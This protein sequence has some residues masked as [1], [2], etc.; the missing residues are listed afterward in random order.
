M[1]KDGPIYMF[2]EHRNLD[3]YIESLKKLQGLAD[4]VETV[5]PCHY[6]TLE[7]DA[8]V[9]EYMKHHRDARARGEMVADPYLLRA[10]EWIEFN[11]AGAVLKP[12]QAV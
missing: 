11:G 4:K 5:L 2:G 7:G 1:Q 8:D 9:A 6:I 10:G 12:A 3:R